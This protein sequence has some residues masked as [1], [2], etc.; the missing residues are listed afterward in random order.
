[1]CPDLF[2]FGDENHKIVI[3]PVCV[4]IC[5]LSGVKNPGTYRIN[6]HLTNPLYHKKK[7]TVKVINILSVFYRNSIA[8]MIQL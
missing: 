1:M 5:L 4:R 7:Y 3:D 6:D 8:D 2:A